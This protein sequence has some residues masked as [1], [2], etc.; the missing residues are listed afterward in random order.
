[1]ALA[2]SIAPARL[3]QR[4]RGGLEWSSASPPVGGLAALVPI[5]GSWWASARSLDEVE[6]DGFT[7]R[8]RAAIP[9]PVFERGH[10]FAKKF[11]GLR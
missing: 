2:P 5:V 4:V 6:V 10:V 11:T 9:K 8:R 1:M 3:V 7:L